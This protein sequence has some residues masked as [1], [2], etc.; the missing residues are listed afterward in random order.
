M[1]DT[2]GNTMKNGSNDLSKR[3]RE[4]AEAFMP[5]LKMVDGMNAT[6]ANIDI[7][8]AT[9]ENWLIREQL[10]DIY[11]K[12]IAEDFE[13]KVCSFCLN[14]F[15]FWISIRRIKILSQYLSFLVLRNV[16][17]FVGILT[18]SQHFSYPYN[19]G[20]SL[21]LLSAFANF[22]NTYFYPSAPLTP[23]QISTFPG[24]STCLD[25]LLYAICDEGDSIIIPS[26]FWC[27]NP[28]LPFKTQR[29]P[30]LL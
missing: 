7:D 3:S 18:R 15:L 8:L 17:S 29:R 10:V 28:L 26:P 9:G 14:I 27:T 5:I 13:A 11:K 22:F 2:V 16:Y 19:I 6:A 1:S 24:A 30:L 4:K 23:H 21:P 20:G 12:T 25:S